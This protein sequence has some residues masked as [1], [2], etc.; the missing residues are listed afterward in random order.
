M[1]MLYTVE[2]WGVGGDSLHTVFPREGDRAI[3]P[4]GDITIKTQIVK[5]RHV[6]GLYEKNTMKWERKPYEGFE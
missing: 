5:K 6:P 1:V 3:Y 4:S 2:D